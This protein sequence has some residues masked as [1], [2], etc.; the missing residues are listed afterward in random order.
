MTRNKIPDV[1][2]AAELYGTYIGTKIEEPGDTSYHRSDILG[3]GV[4][5]KII[6]GELVVCE[7]D[8]EKQYREKLASFMLENSLST[9]HGDTF[10]DLLSELEKNINE[11]SGDLAVELAKNMEK[12]K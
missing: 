8:I 12:R 2:Y 6:A 1:I 10:D 7:R 9:G 4:I 5:D 3:P 11:L